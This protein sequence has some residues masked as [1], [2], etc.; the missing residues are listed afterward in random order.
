MC[1]DHIIARKPCDG[2]ATGEPGCC[3]C[4][5]WCR[6]VLHISVLV[7]GGALWSLTVPNLDQEGRLRDGEPGSDPGYCRCAAWCRWCRVVLLA[8]V[9][10]PIP[11]TLRLKVHEDGANQVRQS[12]V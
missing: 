6:V 9:G 5:D 11:S 2:E 10:R 4:A 7:V 3:R 1:L 12:R 8:S